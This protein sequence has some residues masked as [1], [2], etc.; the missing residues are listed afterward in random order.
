M[1]YDIIAGVCIFLALAFVVRNYIKKA[2]GGGCGC[3]SGG[4]GDGAKKESCCG[5]VNHI[6]DKI[7]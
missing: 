2:K 6:Q 3:G 1:I 4:C 7:K 5:G